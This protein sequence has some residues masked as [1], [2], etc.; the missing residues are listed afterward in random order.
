[1]Q[2][3]TENLDG[4]ESENP[5]A[6][7]YLDGRYFYKALLRYP[8]TLANPL[9]VRVSSKNKYYIHMTENNIDTSM[10]G[11]LRLVIQTPTS[12][13]SNLLI[14]DYALGKV[15]RFEP[16][17]ITAPHFAEVNALVEEYLNIF[18][19]VQLEVIDIDLE[20]ILDQK[21]PQC[22]HSGFCTAYI[23]LYAYA[24]LNEQIYDPRDIR[25]FV[26]K[27]ERTYGTLPLEGAEVEYGLWGNTN[28]NQKRN[29]AI[30]GI[31]GLAIGGLTGG[32]GGAALLGGGG[33][34][35]GSLL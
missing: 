9:T 24:Y 1:M 14:L 32:L 8:G 26:T 20:Q 11:L 6:S 4:W 12:R 27:V 25:R 30:G 33:L 5:S 3:Y 35:V 2:T 16:L 17:G 29:M 28:P 18:F 34:L 10:P 31:S 19:D 15:Y 23:L 21:N 22:V 7:C 13:H